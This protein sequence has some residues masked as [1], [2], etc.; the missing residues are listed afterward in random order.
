MYI[1]LYIGR[2]LQTIQKLALSLWLDR[3]QLGTTLSRDRDAVREDGDD[4]EERKTRG[5]K[6][7]ALEE[8]VQQQVP[9]RPTSDETEAADGAAAVGASDPEHGW[10]GRGHGRRYPDETRRRR[11]TGGRRRWGWGGED[12]G[13][14]MRCR[15]E[16]DI[17]PREILAL[18]R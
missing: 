16:E 12:E 15:E 11:P 18:A 5:N 1:P 10:A 17:P 13:E 14:E 9:A 6:R 8:A 7:Y 4:A 2:G 3:G